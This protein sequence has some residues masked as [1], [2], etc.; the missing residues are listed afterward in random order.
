[1]AVML[2][3]IHFSLLH[4]SPRTEEGPAMAHSWVTGTATSPVSL[5]RECQT[6]GRP[7]SC[8]LSGGSRYSW[9]LFKGLWMPLPQCEI[10]QLSSDI[11]GPRWA[12]PWHGWSFLT[13]LWKTAWMFKDSLSWPLWTLLDKNAM[14]HIWA[15]CFSTT[16]ITRWFWLP[17]ENIKKI[18]WCFFKDCS[19]VSGIWVGICHRYCTWVSAKLLVTS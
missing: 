7:R 3:N 4:S 1:M 17:N 18:L 2:A 12:G 16:W 15:E 6:T 9:A 10:F 14:S 11:P 5:R 19:L 13:L 8:G